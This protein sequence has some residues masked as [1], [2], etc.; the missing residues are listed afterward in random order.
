MILLII[1]AIIALSLFYMANKAN[2]NRRE[3]KRQSLEER[4]E[5]LMEQVRQMK[6][7]QH[8]GPDD[9]VSDTTKAE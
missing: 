9:E 6:N 4:R 7:K 8:K 3:N 1:F 5:A 2:A